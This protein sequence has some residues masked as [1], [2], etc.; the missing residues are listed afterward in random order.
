PRRRVS[1]PMSRRCHHGSPRHVPLGRVPRRPEIG[2]PP[3]PIGAP[4]LAPLRRA[5]EPDRLGSVVAPEPPEL[6]D[7]VEAMSATP[8]APAPG[9]ADLPASAGASTVAPSFGSRA[10]PMRPPGRGAAPAAMPMRMAGPP[11]AA[12]SARPP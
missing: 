5:M 10:V 4:A 3:G 1:R 12:L 7:D 2:A 9:P 6:A 8:P 11:M